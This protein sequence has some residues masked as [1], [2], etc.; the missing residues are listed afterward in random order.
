MLFIIVSRK[1][2][3]IQKILKKQFFEIIIVDSCYFRMNL[4]EKIIASRC[5]PLCKLN[6]EQLNDL[7][8]ATEYS[9]I[10]DFEL[11]SESNL[12]PKKSIYE[13]IEGELIKIDNN[14]D[15]FISIEVH[16]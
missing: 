4:L 2:C 10:I 11:G 3:K 13:F 5:V 9:Q 14:S 15:I 7:N 1:I 16:N 12:F 8:E 6:K